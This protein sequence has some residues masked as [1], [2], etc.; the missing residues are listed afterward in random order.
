VSLPLRHRLT[1]AL[2]LDGIRHGVQSAGKLDQ[3][4]VAYERDD[5]AA[6]RRYSRVDE[7]LPQRV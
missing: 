5:A 2:D 7:F 6:M 3:N 4:T 1:G